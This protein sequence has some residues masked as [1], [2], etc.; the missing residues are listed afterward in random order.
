MQI[1]RALNLVI[2]IERDGAALYVHSKPISS[3]VYDTYWRVLARTF[4]DINA[5]GLGAM[6]PRIAAKMLREVA[7]EMGIWRDDPATKRV[8]VER[9]LMA[10]IHRLTNVLVAGNRGWD[11]VPVDDALKD[12]H[13][14]E[15]DLGEVDGIL[16]FFTAASHLFRRANRAE[17]L[18]GSLGLWGAQIESSDCTEFL[19]SLTIS[20]DAGSTGGNAAA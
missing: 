16:V 19:K 14:D 13:I 4:A 12:G 15:E 3:Q 20:T 17:M 2:P 7:D 18:Q 5:Q 6:G 11:M 1:D 10:E 9:G 8:G